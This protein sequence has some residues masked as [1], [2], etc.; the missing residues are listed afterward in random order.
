MINNAIIHKTTTRV[1]DPKCK[2]LHPSESTEASSSNEGM[3][4]KFD[5]LSEADIMAE[6]PK[7]MLTPEMRMNILNVIE[8][9][10]VSHT[11]SAGAMQCMKKLVMTI[12]VGAFCLLLQAMMQ[13]HTMIQCQ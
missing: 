13:P 5:T 1:W 8:H 3:P 12:L 2:Y 9:M 4:Q 7:D 6:F 11:E 10:E